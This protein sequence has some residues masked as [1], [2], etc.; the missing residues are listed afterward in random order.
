MVLHTPVS[1][2]QPH[3]PARPARKLTFLQG[4]CR[5]LTKNTAISC[6][7]ATPKAVRTYPS[8]A[9]RPPSDAAPRPVAAFDR[10]S[11]RR[12]RRTLSMALLAAALTAPALAAN[13][14]Q[15]GDDSESTSSGEVA[16]KQSDLKSLRAQI[17]AMRREMAAAEGSRKDSLDQLKDADRAISSTQ[18]ELHELSAQ[19]AALQATIKELERQSRALE[20]ELGAQQEQLAKLLY[21]QYLRGTPDPL[22]LFL[23]GD[24][25]HQLARDLYYLEAIGRARSALLASI[26]SSLRRQQAL[27]A[28]SR[29][30]AALLAAAES[31]QTD[32]H[33][34]LLVQREQRQATLDRLSK[35][36]TA[37]RR[38]IGNLERDEKRLT[39]LV[40]RLAKIIAAKAAEAR[41]E[42][43]RQELARQERAR[44]LERARQEHER[45]ERERQEASQEKPA[46]ATAP[47][48]TEEAAS[49]RQASETRQDMPPEAPVAGNLAKMTGALRLP[50]NGSI[51]NR[52]GAARQEGSTW[53][54][55]FIRASAGSAVHSVAGGRVVFAEWMRGFGN[56]LIVDHGSDYLSIYANNDSLLKEVGDDVRAGE[57]VATVGNTGSNPESGLYFEIRYQGKPLDPLAWINGK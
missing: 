42:A 32:E 38:E 48:A 11:G 43:Q 13:D 25:A 3:R 26:E 46:R 10:G 5:S 17:E 14:R 50:T 18:R 41:R 34:K 39:E 28:D 51:S 12:L 8:P 7:D 21:R 20:Q 57:S 52:F 16:A 23:N 33:A 37:Q 2:P 9:P 15:R 35:Q 47:P 49:K 29:Q 31:R 6:R 4:G 36:I 55:L 19:I 53:K 45:H 22:R 56:L 30:Q 40:D 27:A 24:D 54:G 1:W 44:R